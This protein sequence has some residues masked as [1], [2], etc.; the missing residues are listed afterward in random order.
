MADRLNVKASVVVNDASDNS[1]FVS[2][3]V[4]YS[5]VPYDV[6]VMMEQSMMQMLQ[7]W[8]QKGVEE[9]KNKEK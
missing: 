9:K 3:T 5:G 2:S 8:A 6:F 7:G 4:E 1:H